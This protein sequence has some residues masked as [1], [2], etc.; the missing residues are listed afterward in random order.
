MNRYQLINEFVINETKIKKSEPG[1]DQDIYCMDKSKIN[2]IQEILKNER[3]IIAV[4]IS[5][6]G[7]IKIKFL[8]IHDNLFTNFKLG[9][10]E[11]SGFKLFYAY[12]SKDVNENTIGTIILNGFN[13]DI[14]LKGDLMIF[15][16]Y[17]NIEIHS[18]TT[19]EILNNF[20]K[21]FKP[22]EHSYN[23]PTQKISFKCHKHTKNEYLL[24]IYDNT[25][26]TITFQMIGDKQTK[27][28]TN[29]KTIIPIKQFFKIEN[30]LH[31]IYVNKIY[32]V[33]ILKY[34]HTSKK[35]EL[36]YFIHIKDD[37]IYFISKSCKIEH[38]SKYV[39]LKWIK[40]YLLDIKDTQKLQ[41][42]EQFRD[43]IINYKGINKNIDQL[44]FCL[45]ANGK[46]KI[47]PNI[48]NTNILSC[49]VDYKNTSIN[50]HAG[51]LNLISKK[52]CNK[53]GDIKI[54]QKENLLYN[55]CCQ[56]IHNL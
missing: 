25:L 50:Y 14:K 13:K 3:Y 30:G 18:A 53:I 27:F 44:C 38:F 35:H 46:I 19:N 17:I 7:L 16:I 40:L 6:T 8:Q 56:L 31:H 2:E 55:K 5:Y 29:L 12:N 48:V 11:I 33:M 51:F 15:N 26:S 20:L 24:I 23:N 37:N 21:I 54:Y 28:I 1:L 22:I 45:Y 9:N 49:K 36:Y 32:G 4:V 47:I 10:I 41:K 39:I 43:F 42:L 52:K 34:W